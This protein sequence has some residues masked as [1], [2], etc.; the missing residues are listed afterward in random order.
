MPSGH[1]TTAYAAAVA[2]GA[3]W[4]RARV[5]MWIFAG[6][7]A[8]SRVVITAHYVSDVIAAAFVGAFG[9]VLVRNWFAVRRLGFV[10]QPDGTAH[11]LPGPSWRHL[12]AVARRL[13]GQ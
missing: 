1:A 6:V 10:A 5:P 9:A 2:I 13:I 7:I 4:P 3:V 12:K 8:L 11:P